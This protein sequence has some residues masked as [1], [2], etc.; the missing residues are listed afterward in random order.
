MP[1]SPSPPNNASQSRI[2]PTLAVSM[3]GCLGMCSESL[4][5]FTPS[6]TTAHRLPH[7]QSASSSSSPSSSLRAAALVHAHAPA[8]A[9]TTPRTP[10][11][12][13]V[14]ASPSS[15]PSSAWGVLAAVRRAGTRRRRNVPMRA[16]TRS[17]RLLPHILFPPLHPPPH[18][19]RRM[20]ACPHR[21]ATQAT[22]RLGRRPPA[23]SPNPCPRPLRMSAGW[24]RTLLRRPL[25]LACRTPLLSSQHRPR[26]PATRRRHAP[27]DS[28]SIFR[29]LAISSP[30]PSQS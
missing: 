8:P 17:P 21:T 23:L 19:S 13:A 10:S 28:Y 29:T 16:A 6:L 12:P 30:S 15:G 11:R 22:L 27:H 14:V 3:T 20:S 25:A 7:T 2:G 4:L 1:P 9:L 26:H 18:P 5:S 24:P